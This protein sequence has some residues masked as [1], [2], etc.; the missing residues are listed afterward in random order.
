[1]SDYFD[2]K[3]N[4]T[5]NPPTGTDLGSPGNEFNS[6]YVESTITLGNSVVN[7][8][9][10]VSP[11]IVSLQYPGD[12]TAA[13]TNGNQTIIINGFGFQPGAVVYVGSMLASVVS[14][15]NSNTITF[16][17]PALP[18]GNYTLFVINPDGATAIN[19]S[20]IDYSI[21]PSWL[22]P[23]GSL[24]SV[25][26]T[27]GINYSLSATSNGN[28]SYQV[29]SGTIP[30]GTNL[31]SGTGQ[32]SGTAASTAASTTYSF[33]VD[34]VD[35]ENQNTS[36][37]FSVT[38]NPDVV[39]WSSPANNTNY[40][41][42][43]N[44]SFSQALSAS[45]AAGKSI[46]YSANVLPAGLSIVGSNITGTLSSSGVTTSL[47]TAT[48]ADTLRSASR[49]ISFDVAA[50]VAGQQAFT[51][52][53]T[54]SWTAPAGV[55][56]VC[57]V[58]VGGGGG[59]ISG[60]AGGTGGGGGGLGWRNN[61]AVI[62]GQS[63][64]VV[65]GDGG[66]NRTN[67]TSSGQTATAG[68]TSHFI[69]TSTVRGGGGAG[70]IY[71][72]GSVKA[73][74]GT[75]TGGGGGNGG[76]SGSVANSGAGGAGGAGGYAG[77]G[78]AGGNGNNSQFNVAGQGR[79]F[80]G[81]GGGGGGSGGSRANQPSR[82][83]GG[84]GLLGQGSN[85]LG[86]NGGFVGQSSEFGGGGGSGGTNGAF[87]AGERGGGGMGGATNGAASGWGADGAVR[88]IWGAGRAFPSTNT[89]DM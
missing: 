10:I 14:V 73:S 21:V 43:V 7:Q 69:N 13:D 66:Q 60:F 22:T 11:R 16:V 80:D 65:V 62:P 39:T 55:T 53:G 32:L 29:T 54:Y 28:V 82:S 18:A 48:A 86:G 15:I 31:N 41:N 24:G 26:E 42:I 6:V 47:I 79:G 63:Y 57:V 35:T 76:S 44:D 1:M 52:P 67:A 33:V 2:L 88:I 27:F 25:Y 4:N 3:N 56:S 19:P 89:Q 68:G 46:T 51:T 78:G 59:G 61:I 38:V 81:T 85:G 23:S 36:R 17:S 9:T 77:D 84:V 37:S 45:S 5:F 64:T 49:T 72:N 20:G 71:N 50:N 30:P 12:D 58:C 75:F 34:A 40:T 83:G 87:G 8:N 74:G 70:G